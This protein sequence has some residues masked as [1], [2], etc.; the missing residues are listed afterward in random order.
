MLFS[1]NSKSAPIILL[2]LT[3]ILLISFSNIFAQEKVKIEELKRMS[4][5]DLMNVEILVSGAIT[6]LNLAETPASVTVITSEDIFHTPARNILDLIE[7]YVPGVIWMNYEESPQIGMRGLIAN[8]STKYLLLVNDRTMNNKAHFGARPELEQW[9]LSDIQKIEIIRGPGSVTYGPGAIAGIINITTHNSGSAPGFN[10]RVNFL[11]KYNS[12]GLSLQYGHEAAKYKI[13]AYSSIVRTNGFK[14]RHFLAT[15]ENETGYIGDTILPDNEPLDYFADYRDNPQIKFHFDTEF[16]S[17][18]RIWGRYTQQGATWSGNEIKTNFEGKFLNQQSLRNRQWTTV[19][20][21]ENEIKDNINLFT[22]LSSGS[23]DAERITDKMNDPDPDHILNKQVDFSEYESSIYSKINWSTNNLVELAVGGEYKFNK[24]GPGWGDNEKDMR[25]GE[26]G[27]IVS[28]PNSNAIRVGNKGSAD[29]DSTEIFVS[30]GWNSHTYSLFSEANIH[31]YPGF[32][33]LLSGRMDKNTHSN[34]LFSPRMALIKEIYKGHYAKLV[35][36]KSVRMNTA[37]Q[38]YTDHNNGIDPETET[39]SGIEL[40][41]SAYINESLSFNLSGFRNNI[42]IIAWNDE[43]NASNPIGK[44]KLY[45]IEAEYKQSFSN[46][47][48]DASYS[49]VKQI[50]WKIADGVFRSG[51][52]YSDYNQ[53]V[54]DGIQKGFGNDL[55]NWPNQALKFYGRFS[56]LDKI[57]LHID[58][59]SAWDFK[60]S[61]DG[62]TGLSRAVVGTPDENAVLNAIQEVK[63]ANTYKYDFR[64]NMSISYNFHQNF[65]FGLY[66]LNILGAN[67][68]KRYSYDYGN[69]KAAPAGVRFIEEPRVWGIRFD[70]QLK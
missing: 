63:D 39:L 35:T 2:L 15:K 59:R 7:I 11:D 25:L 44:L 69:D 13:Y 38:L 48:F 26:N 10:S 66:G 32:K 5:E 64:L 27:I 17:H 47:N 42:D 36:Q 6:H 3:F 1:K 49:F 68:N 61:L 8:R 21:Y 55:A 67:S 52:S 29:R 24:Y 60:G 23:S 30:S 4:F 46:G 56:P 58:S 9:D 37:G 18:W 22:S 34:R 31:V 57:T 50:D 70:C 12:K 41:Y 16:L 65:A 19:L 45:G 62:L 51:V 40:I 20:Q 33:I 53:Q 28:G 54:G 14:P 43:T